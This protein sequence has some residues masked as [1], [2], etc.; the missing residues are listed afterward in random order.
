MC[1]QQKPLQQRLFRPGVSLQTQTW[2]CLS[3]ASRLYRNLRCEVIKC[4][5]GK[6]MEQASLLEVEIVCASAI[7]GDQASQVKMD[8]A[9]RGSI[10]STGASGGLGRPPAS[11][12][13]L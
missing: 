13:R 10:H 12:G 3:I 9:K 6:W 1:Q 2:T 4:L 5:G 7:R 11:G 8:P